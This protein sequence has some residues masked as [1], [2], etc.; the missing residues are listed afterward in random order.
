MITIECTYSKKLGLPQ[1]CSHQFGITLRTE[2]SDLGAAQA[3]SARLYALL[4]HSVDASL[5]QTGFLPQ[6][7]GH[8]RDGAPDENKGGGEAWHCSPRQKSLILRVADK[9]CLATNQLEELA[10]SRFAKPLRELTKTEASALIHE[11]LR[12][13]GDRGHSNGDSGPGG[14]TLACQAQAQDTPNPAPAVATAKA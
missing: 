6:N 8:K 10:Q 9:K 1:Y 7:N 4:Q 2:L 13:A 3:E 11:L 12:Q 5:Q 14:Q